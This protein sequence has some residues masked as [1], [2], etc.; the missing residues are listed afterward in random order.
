MTFVATVVDPLTEPPPAGW[1]V[2][3]AARRLRPGWH[4]G[5]VRAIDW[6]VSVASSLVIV[7]QT[8]GSQPVGLFQARHFGLANPARFVDVGRSHQLGLTECRTVPVPLEAGFAFAPDADAR[9]RVE[10]V[11]TFEQALRRR[12]GAGNAGIVYRNLLPEHLPLVAGRGRRRWRL[13]PRMVLHNQWPDLTSY[14]ASLPKKWRWQ[15][16]K[17]RHEVEADDTV[18]VE[19]T[20]TIEPAEACW[21]AEVIRLRY[22]PR[23]PPRPPLSAHAVAQVAG[24][25][26]T[27]FL[28]Y[29]DRR[30]RLIGYSTV[31]DDGTELH[32][33]WWG[34][35]GGAD[36]WRENLYFDQYLRLAELMIDTG[37]QRLILGGGMTRIK[38]R[39]GARPEP[40][41]RVIGVMSGPDKPV[42]RRETRSTGASTTPE[43]DARPRSPVRRQRRERRERRADLRGTGGS[44]GKNW[45]VRRLL[46]WMGRSPQRADLTARCRQCGE[47]ASVNVLRLSHRRARYWCERCG[48]VVAL[49]G[50]W[51]LQA[52]QPLRQA[53]EAAARPAPEAPAADPVEA[54]L[55]EFMPPAM[56]RW[57]RGRFRK[58]NRADPRERSIVYHRYKE[59]DAHLA[60]LGRDGAAALA[61][62]GEPPPC[63]GLPPFSQVVGALHDG[64]Y[65]VEKVTAQLRAD[66]GLAP[67]TPEEALRERVEHARRWLARHGRSLCWVHTRRPDGNLVEPDRAQVAAVLAELRAGRLPDPDG[68]RAVHA[69][70]FGT[71]RGPALPAVLRTYSTGEV[72]AALDEYLASGARPLRE[73]VLARLAAPPAPVRQSRPV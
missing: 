47:W 20:D 70:L 25:P 51:Q 32:L 22:T 56:L 55:R 73:D 4:S 39:Y 7:E 65:H 48:A 2:F 62:D 67:G 60:Q 59:W 37:R 46:T 63:P 54:D 3:A 28:T 68:G 33:I 24:L 35:R 15:L 1:D 42:R 10:A 36:G 8:S 17:I 9:D 12:T 19:L 18:R 13:P 23:V 30:D 14:L 38:A 29:R 66:P 43:V 40:R 72:M 71:E 69:G 57:A 27:R 52:L 11:R 31:H 50:R 16:K 44:R 49:T 5:P 45:M 41:W 21:L 64:C 58:P 61:D 6:C 26:G 34:T 53:R